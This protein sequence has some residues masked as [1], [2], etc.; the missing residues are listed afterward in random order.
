MRLAR[1]LFLL[2]VAL[3]GSLL[4]AQEPVRVDHPEAK[5]M[6]A[7]RVVDPDEEDDVRPAQHVVPATLPGEVMTG[8]VI[9]PAQYTEPA[10]GLP[11]PVVTLD[12]EG[13]DVTATGQP[14]VYKLHVRNRS[15]AKAHHVAVKV[16]HPKGAT[17]EMADPPAS[18][19]AE[20]RWELKTLEPGQS[21]TITL[22]YRPT[23]GVEEVKVLARL[24]F[25]FGRGMATKVSAPTL[26]VKKAGPVSA[27]V[28]GDV[29][30]YRITVTN[31]GKVTVKDIEVRETLGKGL[32]YEGREI[33]RGRL[34]GWLTS[35]VDVASGVR[36]WTIPYLPPGRS[37]TLV[38]QAKA[39]DAGVF[40]GTVKVS[41]GKIEEKAETETE[42]LTARLQVQ[43]EG[44]AD[45]KG[46]VDQMARYRV[47][48][49]N[50]GSADL[51]NVVVR[52][53]YPADLRPRSATAGGERFRGTVQWVF[54]EL[55]KGDVKE[56]NVAFST[57]TPGTK[58]IHFTARADKG[59]EQKTQVKTEFTGLPSLD[60][61]VEVPG[62]AAVGKP[63]TYRVTVANRGTAAGKARLQVDLPPTLDK[64]STIPASGEGVGQNAKEVR[65]AEYTFPAGKKT[66]FTIVVDARSAGEAKTIFTLYE[67]GRP[68]KQESKITQVTGSD[69]RSPTGPPPARGVDPTKVG[70]G[71]RDR[72]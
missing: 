19:D 20:G 13:S 33:A 27:V 68:E 24:Q 46:M 62:V 57:G 64:R 60:W 55:K 5:V 9:V 52:C 61:D 25:D 21:R 59:T 14:V 31:T 54:K 44:P 71:P 43:A 38:Y 50:H 56:L 35:S 39:R 28:V 3:A 17:K 67:Q 69:T 18:N 66:T 53:Q 6:P 41:S 23:A 7:R 8:P 47:V 70:L 1:T 65:F 36:K 2:T 30:T 12:I 49:S 10:G 51:R 37:E 4:V 58:T 11:T 48:V 45:G 72:E 34:D 22:A 29:V 40:T 32:V 63:I 26:S 16:T 15:Q 42:V